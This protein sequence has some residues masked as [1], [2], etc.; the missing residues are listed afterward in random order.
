[1]SAITAMIA[2]LILLTH[3]ST[4]NAGNKA[5]MKEIK[6][7][8]KDVCQAP[9]NRGKFW[10][11]SVKGNGEANVKLKLLSGVNTKLAGEASFKRGE[12]EGV[13]Q[14]L[15][16][17]ENSDYRGCVKKLTPLFLEK[18]VPKTSS[19]NNVQKAQGYL[20]PANDPMP[21]NQCNNMTD[22]NSL[23][24]YLGSNMAFTDRFPAN[25]IELSGEKVLSIDKN[26]KGISVSCLLR[27]DDGRVVVAIKNNKFIINPN[28]YWYFEQPD[29]HT[30]VV[31]DQKGNMALNVRYLNKNAIKILGTFRYSTPP[32]APVIID[33]QTIN[34]PNRV[35]IS[36]GCSGNA[37][38]SAFAF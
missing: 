2:I 15:Q 37:G 22:N 1:M 18:F 26:N 4:T 31:Y 21:S 13:L 19:D 9:S 10:E 24:V 35:K 8:I 30:L 5:S 20:L 29:K 3:A 32:H 38:N 33:D 7:N 36:N 17:A 16:A 6:D 14:S 25:I 23:S 28:N 11:V 12:W 34:L 27:S